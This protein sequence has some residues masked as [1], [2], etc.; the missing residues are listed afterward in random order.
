MYFISQLRIIIVCIRVLIIVD[1]I[2]RNKLFNQQ[3]KAL[4][5]CLEKLYNGR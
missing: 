5:E 4:Y 2:L 3:C 1:W